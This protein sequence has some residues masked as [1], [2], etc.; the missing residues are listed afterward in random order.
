MYLCIHG[1]KQNRRF[2]LLPGTYYTSGEA[3]RV[4]MSVTYDAPLGD[5]SLIKYQTSTGSNIS[6]FGRLIKGVKKGG[7]S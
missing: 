4:S 1:E 2:D 3:M 5:R 6:G 7:E